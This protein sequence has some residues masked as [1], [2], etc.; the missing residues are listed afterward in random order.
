M[1][2]RKWCKSC[3]QNAVETDYRAARDK[4]FKRFPVNIGTVSPAT[5]FNWGEV[6][7]LYPPIILEEKNKTKKREN[8][9]ELPTR[10][11]SYQPYYIIDCP[12][13][14]VRSTNIFKQIGTKAA[15][16]LLLKLTTGV[17]FTNILPAAFVPISFCRKSLNLHCKYRKAALKSFVRKSCS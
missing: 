9:A 1:A 4:F 14:L 12:Y 6:G 16:K 15:H 11:N 13:K 7:E 2:K 5:G 10:S 3:S 8:K 17:N